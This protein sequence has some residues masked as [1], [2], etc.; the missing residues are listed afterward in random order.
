MLI[1][2][3]FFLF[4]FLTL[5]YFFIF[6]EKKF[7]SFVISL[8]FSIL[9]LSPYLKR[10][11]DNFNTL[12]LTK[13]FGYNLLKGNNPSFKA[14]GDSIYIE[15]NFDRKTLKIKTDNSYEINLDNFYRDKA[16]NL[17]AV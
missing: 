1:R 7:K 2:G 15:E 12:T 13:S 11:Y 4:Y 9:V 17:I 5:I 10:N 16:I 8:V 3:E 14:E 6:K